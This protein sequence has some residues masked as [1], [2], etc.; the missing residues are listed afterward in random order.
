M[1]AD[2]FSF[3]FAADIPDE[4]AGELEN[5][6]GSGVSVCFDTYNNGAIPPGSVV[7]GTALVDTTGGFGGSGVLKLTM[8]EGGQTGSFLID[9]PPGINSIQDF[10]AT[11]KVLIG[12][13]SEPPADGF[14]FVA[15]PDL[16][17]RAFNEDGSGTGLVVSFDTCNQPAPSAANGLI[18]RPPHHLSRFKPRNKCDS[19]G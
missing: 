7:L 19:I 9:T 11:W 5:G 3:N 17:D 10:V 14:C 6:M 12:G 8:A 4:A 2:G 18:C 15:G 13:G 1:P 16:A